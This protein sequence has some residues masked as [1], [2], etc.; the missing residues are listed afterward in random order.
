MKAKIKVLLI[1]HKKQL[2]IK[3]NGGIM[4]YISYMRIFALLLLFSSALYAQ[5]SERQ[6]V[7]WARTTTQAITLDG[8]LNESAWSSAETLELNYGQPGKLPTSGWKFEFN[9]AAITDPTH[10]KIKFLVSGNQLYLGFTMPDSSVGGSTEFLRCDGILMSI[11]DKLSSIRPAPFV[12]FFYTYWYINKPQYAVPGAPPRFIGNRYGNFT[13][14]TRTAAQIAVWDAKTVVNGGQSNDAGRDQS[15]VVEMRIAMDSLGYN[16][17]RTEGDIIMLNFSIWDNDYLYE[18]VPSIINTTR[19]HFQSPWGNVNENN[20]ARIHTQPDVTIATATLPI[21]PPDIVLQ[22]GSTYP[23]PVIDGLLNDAVWNS[24]NQFEIAWGDQAIRNA[25]A[26]IGPFQSGEFQ[27]LLAGQT[28]KPA[29]I[30][31]SYG[32]FK[33][34]FRDNF[35]YLSADVNDLLVEGTNTFDEVDGLGLLIGDRNTNNLANHMEVRLLRLSFAANDTL[36]AYDYM[37]QMLDSNDVQFEFKLKGLTTVGNNTDIDEGFTVEM[38]VKLTGLLGYTA[39]LGDKLIFLG[40]VLY[41]GDLFDDPLSNYGT[42]T[43]W[44]RENGV[45][46]ALAWGVMDPNNTVDVNDNFTS[47]VPN[48]LVLYGNYPNP[49]N[50]YTTIKYSAPVSG[51][52]NLAIYNALGQ[53]VMSRNLFAASAGAQEYRINLNSLTS[54]VYFYKISIAD[55]NTNEIF[56]SSIGKMILM[57]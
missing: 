21:V 13:D 2:I 22:N 15:W 16:L 45:G 53:E 46:P 31:P 10:A 29:V 6:D 18:G 56:E 57:K 1:H 33:M 36:K 34:F 50:P 48:S 42:R 37:T 14:T 20:V 19:T 44:F 8:V 54:G 23:E 40:V 9:E 35:L 38:K 4:N 39:D 30:D 5:Y 26:G 47:L 55:P 17:T 43:W 25:Y 52:A 49:F 3:Q 24:V 11:K 12:E 41:D 51:N 7:I 32:K 28:T 27:P